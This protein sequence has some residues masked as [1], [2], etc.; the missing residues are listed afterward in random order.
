M[1]NG[2]CEAPKSEGE[3]YEIGGRELASTEYLRPRA[4]LDGIPDAGN[5]KHVSGRVLC[6]LGAWDPGPDSGQL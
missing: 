6:L 2:I 1:S 5:M 4:C 3:G